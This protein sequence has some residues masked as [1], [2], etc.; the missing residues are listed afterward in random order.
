[1][2]EL[3]KS[4]ITN[5]LWSIAFAILMY[6]YYRLHKT[7]KDELLNEDERLGRTSE[8]VF[9]YWFYLQ[10]FVVL[11]DSIL[12]DFIQIF[13]NVSPISNNSIQLIKEGNMFFVLPQIIKTLKDSVPEFIKLFDR[14]TNFKNSTKN[15]KVQK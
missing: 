3:V 14:Y 13:I 11:Y 5:F 4:N 8:R 2:I 9:L 1:M 7:K 15:I 10:V 6:R 12:K